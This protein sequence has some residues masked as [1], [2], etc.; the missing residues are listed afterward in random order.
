M[1][2]DFHQTFLKERA[3]DTKPFFYKWTNSLYQGERHW[4]QWGEACHSG[5]R[6]CFQ[7]CFL[8]FFNSM[9]NANWF[10]H[11]S[12]HS[13]LPLRM[14]KTKTFGKTSNYLTSSRHPKKWII[15]CVAWHNFLLSY[16][17]SKEAHPQTK[18]YSKLCIPIYLTFSDTVKEAHSMSKCALFLLLGMWVIFKCNK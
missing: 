6:G 17:H 2:I 7:S 8:M 10:S 16:A 11:T 18:W 15:D 13:T 14:C 9:P 1:A 3:T 12:F 5:N 4:M